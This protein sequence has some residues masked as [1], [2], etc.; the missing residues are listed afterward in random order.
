MTYLLTFLTS[1]VPLFFIFF[2]IG[3]RSNRTNS[4]TRQ[5]AEAQMTINGLR[6]AIVENAQED[7]RK[8]LLESVQ[9]P[10]ALVRLLAVPPQAEGGPPAYREPDERTTEIG[11]LAHKL[12]WIKTPGSEVHHGDI[13]EVALWMEKRF[14]ELLEGQRRIESSLR[15][16][17]PPG[18]EP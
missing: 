15:K 14:D 9:S 3:R 8:R 4:T 12:A 11:R 7:E 5:L 2:W 13:H 10:R 6:Q 18:N 17:L 1:A 16:A